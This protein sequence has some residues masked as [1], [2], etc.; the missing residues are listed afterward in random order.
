LENVGLLL[1]EG[2]LEP[3]LIRGLVPGRIGDLNDDPPQHNTRRPIS[4]RSIVCGRVWS[5]I[6]RVQVGNPVNRGMRVRGRW[7]RRGKRDKEA[8]AERR[9][10][11]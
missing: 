3:E 7:R 2:L 10:S 5:A 4:I 8:D 9:K 6:G 11:I 1:L